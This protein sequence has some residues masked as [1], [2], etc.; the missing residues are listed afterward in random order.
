M[1]DTV[2]I[3]ENLGTRTSMA[4]TREQVIELVKVYDESP[5]TTSKTMSWSDLAPKH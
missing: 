1:V 4:L 5:H 2:K 3:M